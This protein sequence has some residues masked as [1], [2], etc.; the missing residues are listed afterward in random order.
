MVNIKYTIRRNVYNL[1]KE[2]VGTYDVHK[3]LSCTDT[4][5]EESL[6]IAKAEAYHGEYTVE[7]VQGQTHEPTEI[8]QLRADVDDLTLAMADMLGGGA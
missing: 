4:T 5:F 8:E 7:D 6:K 2:I 1:D 3:T